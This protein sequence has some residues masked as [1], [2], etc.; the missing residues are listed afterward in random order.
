M[1]LKKQT[2]QTHRVLRIQWAYIE[3][4]SVRIL[5]SVL[6]AAVDLQCN[7]PVPQFPI[8]QMGIMIVIELPGAL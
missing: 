2:N 3:M 5:N 4:Q 6:D 7:H 1:D 8:C